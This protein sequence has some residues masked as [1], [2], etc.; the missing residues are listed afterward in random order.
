MKKSRVDKTE[1][2]KGAQERRIGCPRV[3]ENRVVKSEGE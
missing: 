2:D 3:K 1:R